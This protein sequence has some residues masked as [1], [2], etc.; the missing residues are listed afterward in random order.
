MDQQGAEAPPADQFGNDHRD[1]RV[2]VGGG[3][4]LHHIPQR[5]ERAA[6][7]GFDQPQGMVGIEAIPRVDEVVVARL[8]HMDHRDGFG[9]DHLGVLDRAL[10]GPARVAGQH[11][12]PIGGRQGGFPDQAEAVGDPR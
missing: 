6:I 10:R 11:E 12:G 5:A 7:V 9:P 4:L 8:A 2:E 3:L 1:E